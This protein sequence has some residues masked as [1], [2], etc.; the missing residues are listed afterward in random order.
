[1]AESD[2]VNPSTALAGAV[3]DALVESGVRE[4]VLCPGS[5]SCALAYAVHAAERAG[6]LRLHV[7]VDERSAGFLALG[8]A[9]VSR[10]PAAVVTTSGT[11]VANL[12]PAV[13]E[14][15][16]A[17][18]PL[19][20]LSADRPAEMRGT[21]ANQTTYQPGI[22]A[23][24]SRWEC[25]LSPD[26]AA[27]EAT[28]AVAQAVAA[29][30]AVRGEGPVH[31]NVQFREP[32]VPD[33]PLATDAL[34]TRTP[35]S[36]Q[37][38]GAA[39]EASLEPGGVVPAS[40]ASDPGHGGR[41][42]P[43]RTLVVLGDLP[44]LGASQVVLDWAERNAVPVLAEPF[45]PHPRPD[46]VPHG[47]LVAGVESFL[48]AHEPDLVIV[49]GRPT[50]S[51][52]V[53]RL[54]R[55]PGP[56]LLLVDAGLEL[57][58]VGRHSRRESLDE[59]LRRAVK[60]PEQPDRA[61]W[62][63]W[64]DA[65]QRVADAVNAAPPQPGTGPALARALTAA[66]P[67]KALVFLGSSNTPRDF[68]I[69]AH[70]DRPLDIVASRGLAGIDGC[71]STAVGLAL[72]APDRPVYAVLGDLTFLHDGNGLLLGPEEP[73]PDLTIVVANDDGGGIFTTL[74]PGEPERGEA[75]E[76]LFGTPTGAD[77]AALCRAHGIR[78][79]RADDLT[80]L[81]DLVTARPEGLRVV[82][83]A[84]DRSTHRAERARLRS[85]AAAALA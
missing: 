55:R 13:L 58:V 81:A 74:E 34:A 51:R 73:G 32:L 15:R 60:Q 83:I 1:V 72:A 20:V 23:R 39:P 18:V 11:A 85:L 16:H 6:R 28:A 40:A 29:A 54:L 65:G 26:A 2:T 4:V 47:V 7:R 79:D 3:V 70:R 8:L 56:D 27:A 78:H 38:S 82:E 77:L 45:G 67:E 35:T 66:L 9:K 69:A 76:R 37:P 52:P 59:L 44:T 36:T 57:D 42:L 49:V 63:S 43:Q 21:G 64:I 46:A 30:T 14:A 25:D 10:V 75:F 24:S 22:F 17:L 80:G 61:W 53:S 12:H 71:V 41:A 33:L 84:L 5:R 50:L 19:L 31:V 62:Q 48:A 68:D